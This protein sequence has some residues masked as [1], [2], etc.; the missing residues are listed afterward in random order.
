MIPRE[1]GKP[2]RQDLLISNRRTDAGGAEHRSCDPNRPGPLTNATHR[3][4]STLQRDYKVE[5][6]HAVEHEAGRMAFLRQL[7]DE[8]W[9]GGFALI[10][11]SDPCR[12]SSKAHKREANHPPGP[13]RRR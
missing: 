2:L 9:T 11:V 7:R 12:P 8:G 10:P 4:R 13:P 1:A 6:A 3:M 5:R